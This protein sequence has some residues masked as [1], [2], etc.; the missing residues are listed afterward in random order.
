MARP[1]TTLD[2]MELGRGTGI[3]VTPIGTGLWAVEGGEWGSGEDAATL[4][5]IEAAIE[6]GVNFFDTAD[7]YADGHSEELLGRA[8][9]GRRDRFVVATKIGW[10]DFDW[11]AKRSKYD[12]VDKVVGDV[13]QSLRRLQTDYIDVLQLHIDFDEPNTPVLMEAFRTLKQAGTIR[14]WGVSTGQ[15]ERLHQLDADGDCDTLQ[16]DYSILNRT[17]EQEIFPYCQERGIGVIVRGALAMG[18]LTGKYDEQASFP[19][20]DFRRQWIEDPEQH[21]QF[22][23]DLQV[24][25]QLRPLVPDDQ[26]MAQLALRFAVAHPA[27]TT[28]I[29]GARNR[30]QAESNTAA[31]RL[32]DLSAAEQQAIDAIVP[33]GG[34]RRIWPA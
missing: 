13:E 32:P 3:E 23:R 27:V 31:A 33:P 26:S 10:I 4:D 14:A 20:G 28:V 16:I 11:E 29:P 18:L 2:R 8:L 9:R 5:A 30:R 17:P 12:S 7:K 34:G 22:R 15:L 19:E 6:G 1:P 25:D 24:V 21:E